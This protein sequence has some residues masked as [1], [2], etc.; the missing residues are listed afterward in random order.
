[1]TLPDDR[2]QEIR[3]LFFAEHWRVGT[4]AAQL[5]VHHEAIERVCGLCSERRVAPPREPSPLLPYRDFLHE[6]LAQYPRLRAPRLF[7]MVRERGYQGSVRT[8]RDFVRTIRPAP[9]RQVFLRTEVLPGEQA[10]IDW[11]H[12]GHVKVPGGTRALWAFVMVLAYSRALW[13]ELLFDLDVWSVRRSLVRACTA[14]GGSA[15]E[16]LFDN[17]KTIVLE[18]S[19]ALVRFH[20]SLL[21]TAGAYHAQVRAC[22]V[23][24][25]QHKGKVERSIRYLRDSFFAGRSLHSR[26]AG[27]AQL[28]A[29]IDETAHERPH[30]TQ[31]GRSVRDVLSEE[32]SRLLTLPK[33]LPSLE[34][35][36]PIA[37][38]K[39]ATIAFDGN[40]YSVPPEHAYTTRM[41][42]ADD[43]EVRVLDGAQPV[44]VHARCWGRGQRVELRAHRVELLRDRDAAQVPKARERLCAQVPQI[45]A[46]LVRWIEEGRNM[47][48]CVARTVHL[49]DGYGA[50]VLRVAVAE[51]IERGTHDFGA[52]ALLCEQTRRGADRAVRP[53]IQ[54]GAHVREREVPPHAME[55][56]DERR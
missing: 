15:R 39:T 46:L 32:K 31:R 43:Q 13:A 54:L 18:R 5:D 50:E 30:P 19:G 10:Q 22:G 38:D 41:L 17:P 27:N 23:R 16:W 11:M 25:P 21:E 2:V 53:V 52:L 29:W 14:F 45:D 12:V 26:E 49:L 9:N 33:K 6:Q 51:M 44:A 4:I 40:R 56:Y 34:R 36:E 8:V 55:A 24:K 37:I 28:A 35:V 48:G 1:M 7:Q 3:R 20:P 47:G 42:A